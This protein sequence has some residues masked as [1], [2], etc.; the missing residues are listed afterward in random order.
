MNI[1]QLIPARKSTKIQIEFTNGIREVTLFEL[2]VRQ[3]K[4]ISEGTI[5]NDDYS[6]ITDNS[7]M[8]EA[9]FDDLGLEA[10]GIIFQK[11]QEL[12][13]GTQEQNSEDSKKN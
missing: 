8:T 10:I 5:K 12:T 3:I 7:D 9:E 11:L 4:Q 6:L 13:Y 2:R 1:E